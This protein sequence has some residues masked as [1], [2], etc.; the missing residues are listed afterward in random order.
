MDTLS[1]T[2]KAIEADPELGVSQFR[3]TNRWLGGNHNRSTVTG[4]YAAK[5][6]I[7]HKTDV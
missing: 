1:E 7:P 5:Q 3:V 6:E 4:F 2:V